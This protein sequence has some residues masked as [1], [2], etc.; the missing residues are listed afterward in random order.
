MDPAF[1]PAKRLATLVRR[2]EV[3]CLEL[4]DHFTARVERLD[5]RTNVVVV[6][7][8]DRA[9]I[10]LARLLEQAWQ[11]FVPPPGWK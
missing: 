10:H 5:R 2:D 6:R 9:T 4:L 1:L 8:F 7:D 11:R 3:G